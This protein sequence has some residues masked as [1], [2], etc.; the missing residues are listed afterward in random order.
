MAKRWKTIDDVALGLLGVTLALG[1]AAFAYLMITDRDRR[2][3]FS[4]AEHLQI[5]AKPSTPED[6]RRHALR[7]G[8]EREPPASDP[9]PVGTIVGG[10][11]GV[12]APAQTAKPVK[13]DQS[14][15]SASVRGVFNG[16]ALVQTST[17][18]VLVGPGENIPGV[19][20]VISIEQTLQGPRV[21]TEQGVISR[22]KY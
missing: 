15:N 20:N 16:R 22:R 19:G 18:V 12:I 13:S 3:V 6:D 4:G 21:V 7:V 5:F 10:P 2:P 1:S 14:L 9:T 17:T 8:G 11:G